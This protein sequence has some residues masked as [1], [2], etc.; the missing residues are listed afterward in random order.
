[1]WMAVV[2]VF[3]GST[4]RVIVCPSCPLLFLLKLSHAQVETNL[5]AWVPEWK[6]TLLSCS[7]TSLMC[8]QEVGARHLPFFPILKWIFIAVPLSHSTP[9]IECVGDITCHV[10]S[11]ISRWGQWTF[12][13]NAKVVLRPWA[14]RLVLWWVRLWSYHSQEESMGILHA[15]EGKG[16]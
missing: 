16:I 1:M 2:S 3:P 10:S 15:E 8:N 9:Q 7:W 6:L 14:L 4:L 11:D 12:K 5:S 13:T